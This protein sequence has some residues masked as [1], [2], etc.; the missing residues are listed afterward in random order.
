MKKFILNNRWCITIVL[1][2]V[3]VALIFFPPFLINICKDND[4]ISRIEIIAYMSQ[5]VSA[6]FV[7]GG[8]VIAGWQYYLTSRSEITKIEIEQ[9]QR[10]IDLSEYYKNN[11]LNPFLAIQHVYAKADIIDIIRSVKQSEIQ[12]FDTVEIDRLF[13]KENIK[14]LRNK[15]N[16]DEFIVAVLE[17][18]QIYGLNLCMQTRETE[19]VKEDGSKEIKVEVNK[20]SLVGSF[21]NAVVTNT[22]NNIEFFAMHFTHKT[23]DDTVVYQSLHQTY[24]EIVHTL[25]YNIAK[26]NE[27]L[28]S[29]YYTNLI[30]LYLLWREENEEQIDTM[31]NASRSVTN[32]GTTVKKIN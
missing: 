25:Y 11:I 5:I 18:N 8:V 31:A 28:K 17:A 30:D 10:A 22:L 14:K 26:N 32:K 15:Q 7:I 19:C 20:S 24:L 2:L 16:S 1:L 12:N 3:G 6:V 4:K 23:A 13:T 29:K 9:V 21:M 27:P